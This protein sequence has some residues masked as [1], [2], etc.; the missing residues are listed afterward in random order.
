MKLYSA[1]CF[2]MCMNYSASEF[3]LDKAQYL[4]WANIHHN[5]GVNDFV[6]NRNLWWEGNGGCVATACRTQQNE[7]KNS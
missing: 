2:E 4:N 1:C 3:Q 5:Y 7:K 6:K